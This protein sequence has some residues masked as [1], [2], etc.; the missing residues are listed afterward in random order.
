MEHASSLHAVKKTLE[1]ERSSSRIGYS[2]MDKEHLFCPY[3]GNMMRLDAARG[4]AYSQASGHHVALR[5][6]VDKV[7]NVKKINDVD[8]KSQGRNSV[9]SNIQLF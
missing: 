7:K 4:T 1:G 8:D 3:S 9:S 6:L 5:D 2:G